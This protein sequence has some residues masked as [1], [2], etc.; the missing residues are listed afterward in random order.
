MPDLGN[1]VRELS[2]VIDGAAPGHVNELKRLIQ[3]IGDTRNRGLKMKHMC[4]K[5]W[6]L[7]A[8]SDSNYAGDKD[9]RKS[10]TG[11]AILISG[12]PISWKSKGQLNVTL[13]SNEAEY[14]VLC[15]TVRE[16]KFITQL[17]SMMN[18]EFKKPIRIHVDNIGAVFLSENTNSSE[19]TKHIDIK[20][21]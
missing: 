17:L 11:F 10:I 7:E 9:N 13:S 18:I 3:F 1:P 21:H 8:Y 19:R 16:V 12:V 15:E 2:K 4:K 5:V 20:Y 6:E 14:V